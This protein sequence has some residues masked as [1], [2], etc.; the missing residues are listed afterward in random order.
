MAYDSEAFGYN[1]RPQFK[2]SYGFDFIGNQ[3]ISSASFIGQGAIINANNS[4]SDRNIIRFGAGTDIYAADQFTLNASYLF[5]YRD[6]YES[7]IG[8][9]KAKYS[10]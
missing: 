9:L 3:Q 1:I 7:H 10:F 5:E 6:T 8:A 4:K 2:L